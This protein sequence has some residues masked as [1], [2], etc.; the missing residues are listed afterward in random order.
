MG[1]DERK[2]PGLASKTSGD[3]QVERAAT[4]IGSWLSLSLFKGV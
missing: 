1:A 4:M 2:P 3:G